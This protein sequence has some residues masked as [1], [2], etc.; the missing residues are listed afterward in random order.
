MSAADGRSTTPKHRGRVNRVR[1]YRDRVKAREMGSG[2]VWCWGEHRSTM[3]EFRPSK[4][5]V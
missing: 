3:A 5:P 2:F 1:E 4:L